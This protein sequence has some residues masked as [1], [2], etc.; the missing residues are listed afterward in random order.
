MQAGRKALDA[1]GRPR[2]GA[3]VAELGSC[4]PP[5]PVGRP[6]CGVIACR[7]R[8]HPGAQ[9]RITDPEGW[10]ITVFTTNSKAG[11]LADLEVRHRLRARAEDRICGLKDTGMTHLPL[12]AFDKNRIW[13]ELADFARTCSPEL[14]CWRGPT[15]RPDVG[16]Q[17]AGAAAAATH[18]RGTRDHHR[19][20]TDLAPQADGPGPT[21]SPA[22]TDDSP[23]QLNRGPQTHDQGLRTGEYSAGGQA[24]SPHNLKP[25]R[26]LPTH[27]TTR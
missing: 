23:P 13:L 20:P 8:P 16:A 18:G 11:R 7:E 15:G 14:S 12:P 3:Q 24:R 17:A 10:R 9:L 4:R 19:P 6:G 27:R 5:S 2:D 26:R 1:D 22:G 25:N 21:S